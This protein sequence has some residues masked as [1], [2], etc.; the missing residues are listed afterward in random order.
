MT[1]F[2]TQAMDC[3]RVNVGVHTAGTTVRCVSQFSGFSF[4]Y[5]Y[6]YRSL[7][8]ELNVLILC[9]K[10]NPNLSLILLLVDCKCKGIYHRMAK[11]LMNCECHIINIL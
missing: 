10:V 5:L 11:I 7:K 8:L 9:W 3:T 4:D 2:V 6:P 1:D